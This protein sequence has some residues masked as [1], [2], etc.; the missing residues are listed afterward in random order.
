L[1]IKTWRRAEINEQ[2][3]AIYKMFPILE[4]RARQ[5]AGTLCGGE[6]QMLAIA[7]A[8]VKEAYLGG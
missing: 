3:N 7:R 4:R 6:Q 5:I 8:L 1:F 2:I